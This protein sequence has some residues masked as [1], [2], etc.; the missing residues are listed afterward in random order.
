MTVPLTIRVSEAL[1]DYADSEAQRRGLPT[2]EFLA[3]IIARN[4]GRPEL[5][6]IPRKSFGRPRKQRVR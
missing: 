5:G 1:K 3:E 2:N 6:K 4:L